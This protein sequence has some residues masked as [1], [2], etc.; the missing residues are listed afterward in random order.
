MSDPVLHIDEHRHRG[1]IRL[2]LSGELDIVGGQALEARLDQLRRTYRGR[3]VIDL[4]VVTFVSSTGIAVLVHAHSYAQH[5]GWVLELR[6]G[7]SDVRRVFQICGLA[8][9]LPF[10][11]D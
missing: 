11:P 10:R 3:L 6:Q 1:T 5:D 8:D 7:P 9:R 4:S 2:A